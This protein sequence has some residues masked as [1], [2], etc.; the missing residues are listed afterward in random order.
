MKRVTVLHVVAAMAMASAMA[1]PADQA[2]L[3]NPDIAGGVRGAA[4]DTAPGQGATVI[5]L[6]EL[7]RLGIV[8]LSDGP[9]MLVPQRELQVQKMPLP[10]GAGDFSAMDR[11][12]DYF[13]AN[14]IANLRGLDP[15]FLR[16][17][18]DVSA[19]GRSAEPATYVIKTLPLASAW[20]DA[21]V[22]ERRACLAERCSASVDL[23]V[24]RAD[25]ST[26]LLATAVTGSF[27]ALPRA[28]RIVDCANQQSVNQPATPSIVDM[29]GA[30]F[31]L[32]L[33]AGTV[34]SCADAGTG[35]EVLL[36]YAVA[37]DGRK[38]Y[39]LARVVNADGVLITERRFRKN[40]KVKF[41]AGGRRYSEEKASP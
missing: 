35:D 10:K 17:P 31:M 40:D 34:R 3:R 22:S 25:G 5:S 1:W 9:M 32:P 14:T 18:R 6:E 38:A 15:S 2:G 12:D 7:R 21:P 37:D 28:H 30:R 27:I 19:P 20:T 26:Q 8:N 39:T 11:R 36:V 33:H 23:L 29:H 41:R 4:V 16:T 24:N 13:I